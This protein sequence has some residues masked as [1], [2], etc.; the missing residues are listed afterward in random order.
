MSLPLHSQAPDFALPASDGRMISLEKDFQGKPV[1]LYFYPKDFTPGCTKE[2]CSFR[3][4]FQQFHD[5]EVDIL[6]ISKDS[7]ERHQ[8]FKATH[9]LPFELLADVDGAV[10]AKYKALIPLVKLPKRITYLLDAA[11]KI[12]GIYNNMFNAAEHVSQMLSETKARFS[13]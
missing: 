2:A 10:C 8:Q 4:N 1:I 12:V 5:L 3:D 13:K 6:G 7:V 9:T 11:H